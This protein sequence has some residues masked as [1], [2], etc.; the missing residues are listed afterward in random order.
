MN[1]A[2]PKGHKTK[3]WYVMKRCWDVSGQNSVAAE[4]TV[5]IFCRKSSCYA[6]F[7]QQGL[8]SSIIDKLKAHIF[9]RFDWVSAKSLGLKTKQYTYFSFFGARCVFLFI[10]LYLSRPLCVSLRL[11]ETHCGFNIHITPVF[12]QQIS[13][14]GYEEVLELLFYI[15]IKEWSLLWKNMQ[16]SMGRINATL[17]VIPWVRHYLQPKKKKNTQ[18][19]TGTECHYQRGCAQQDQKFLP[20]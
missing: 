7:N 13:Q 15:S 9:I 18:R 2:T 1:K 8:S 19:D 3:V 6:T 12:W 14:E 20:F 4:R 5:S 11:T 10:S 16:N 17:K